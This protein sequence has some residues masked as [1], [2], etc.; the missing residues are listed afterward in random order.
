MNH[1]RMVDVLKAQ[2]M[3]KL[4]ESLVREFYEGQTEEERQAKL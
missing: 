3:S 2:W 4:D 1:M